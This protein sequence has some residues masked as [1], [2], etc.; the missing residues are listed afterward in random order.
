M[1]K[2]E[3]RMIETQQLQQ[4]RMEIVDVDGILFGFEPKFV[5]RAVNVTAAH[6]AASQP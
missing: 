3:F 2:S 6:A 4:C 1:T 5:S